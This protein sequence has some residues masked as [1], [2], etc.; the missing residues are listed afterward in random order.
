[1]VE[2]DEHIE[3]F[4]G[5][6]NTD[7]EEAVVEQIERTNQF[8]L[9]LFERLLSQSLHALMVNLSVIPQ[10][11]WISLAVNKQAG[12]NVGMGFHDCLACLRKQVCI[13]GRIHSEQHTVVVSHFALTRHTLNVNA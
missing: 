6:Q 12:L 9:Q 1:M 5:L 7:A 3:C 10:Q 4:R 11:S 2:I 8:R 13:N